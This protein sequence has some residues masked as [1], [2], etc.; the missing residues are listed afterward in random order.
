M[1]NTEYTL[2][3]AE[4]GLRHPYKFA[5][6]I[7]R[8]HPV[9]FQGGADPVEIFAHQDPDTGIDLNLNEVAVRELL[10]S[11]QLIDFTD[12]GEPFPTDLNQRIAN[13]EVHFCE[14]L[15]R[16]KPGS[17]W[18]G[19]CLVIFE[20]VGIELGIGNIRQ[21]RYSPGNPYGQ[22]FSAIIE[23]NMGKDGLVWAKSFARKR[24]VNKPE[25]LQMLFN[26]TMA[27]ELFHIPLQIQYLLNLKN[28]VNQAQKHLDLRLMNPEQASREV[29][30]HWRGPILE[31]KEIYSMLNALKYMRA[32][33]EQ[34]APALVTINS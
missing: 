9:L 7:V 15:P 11:M 31:P 21:F 24:R 26:E 22:E 27:H 1:F 34:G 3:I 12:S 8:D 4:D 33:E 2:L 14:K 25:G 32:M 10:G 30:K 13:L 23:N 20:E 29:N 18:L 28:A 16:T 19:N 5:S 17:N 6:G